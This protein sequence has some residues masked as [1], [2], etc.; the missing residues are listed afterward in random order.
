ML[1]PSR[2]D[3]SNAGVG[4][5][6]DHFVEFMKPYEQECVAAAHEAGVKLIR[7]E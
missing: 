2:P 5:A 7:F 1:L 3:A 6:R 4:V